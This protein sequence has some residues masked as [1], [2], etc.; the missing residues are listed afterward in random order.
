MSDAEFPKQDEPHI[1][2]YEGKVRGFTERLRALYGNTPA[3]DAQ[4]AESASH[5]LAGDAANK[6]TTI[7]EGKLRQAYREAKEANG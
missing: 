2:D 6:V 1:A 3:W 7:D 4:I 5:E